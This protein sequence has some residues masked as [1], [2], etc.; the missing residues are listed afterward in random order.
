MEDVR[1]GLVCVKINN[2]NK[3]IEMK[4]RMK[5]IGVKEIIF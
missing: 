1:G 5:K 3:E 4:K 2:E